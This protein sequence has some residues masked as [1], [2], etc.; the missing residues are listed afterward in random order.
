MGPVVN[1][2]PTREEGERAVALLL[3]GRPDDPTA[4]LCFNDVCASGVLVAL[5]DRG[6][7]AGRDCAVI[8]FDNIPEAANYRPALTTI[9]IG[10]RQIGQEAANLL[11]RRIKAPS[12]A[13]ENVVLP[14]RLII[15]S[16]CGGQA[17]QEDQTIHPALQPA[18]RPR[19]RARRKAHD[20]EHKN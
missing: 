11:L 8:G 14:P 4:I 6:L 18:T 7:A 16:S 13:P 5:A 9:E 19:D 15:R 2:L 10:A 17:N 12:G 1:C 3:R 20:M